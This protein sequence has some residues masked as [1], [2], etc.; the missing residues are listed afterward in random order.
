[1]PGTA[2]SGAR[3]QEQARPVS[4]RIPANL[5]LPN[6]TLVCGQAAFA[7]TPASISRVWGR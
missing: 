1:V 4:S 3:R 7:Y 6:P 2:P 5:D